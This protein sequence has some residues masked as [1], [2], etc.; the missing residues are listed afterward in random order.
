M[1]NAKT[2]TTSVEIMAGDALFRVSASKLVEKGFYSVIK[3][4]SAKEEVTGNL[5]SL[6][7]DEVLESSHS[8][9]PE[10]HFTQ[11]PARYSDASIVRT[12]EEKGIG[13]PSTYAPIISVLLDRYYVTRN[14]KQLM[15]TILG[16]MICKILVEAFPDVINE[17]FTADV[18]NT[19]DSEW[20]QKLGVDTDKMYL[21]QPKSQSAE[22][23]FDL[24]TDAIET[25]DIGL[26]VLDSI[27]AMVSQDEFDKDYDE[28]SFGG[29]SGPLSRFAKKVEMLCAKYNCTLIGIN[30]VRDD[31]NSTWGGYK[32][33]GG[34]AWK[35]NCI[36]RLEFRRGKF[37]DE[38]GNDL[39][40]SAETPA[41]NKVEMTMVKNKTCPPNRR[42]GFYTLK[43]D[44]GI[45]YLAD[46]VEVALKYEIIEK[47]GAWF[48]IPGIIDEKIQGQ[49]GVKKYLEEHSDVLKQVEDLI[50]SKI[51]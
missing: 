11:G 37:I 25:G 49:A 27:A 29:I 41:G 14:N 5:P 38:K 2:A 20:A 40:N 15:P 32:T 19:L 45:D 13:R 12:L 31:V 3:L 39:T 1:T 43:Y 42:T 51:K 21:L 16:K 34:R 24:I 8:F 30:Q 28:K 17:H 18:E 50:D 6:K 4:L 35:H 23:I 36:V 22:Q 9:Y 44:V 7:K 46:L 33:P 26:V 48:T 10:Q 47:A